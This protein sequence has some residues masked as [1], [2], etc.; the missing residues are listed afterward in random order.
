MMMMMI[1]SKSRSIGKLTTQ[2]MEGG[3]QGITR[4]AR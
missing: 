4:N 1:F 2:S 3:S